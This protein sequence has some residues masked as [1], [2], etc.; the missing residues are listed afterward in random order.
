MQANT[1]K[2]AVEQQFSPV[3]ENYRTSAVHA[4]GEDLTQLVAAARLT[5][6]EV[7][8][9]AGSGAG[10]TALAVAPHAARVVAVDLSEAML[11]QGARGAEERGLTNV[12]F[13]QGDVE[14]LP[15]AAAAFD[16][17]VSR[18]SAHHWPHPQ[19]ALGEFR[20]LLRPGGRFLLS[21][22]VSYD[23]FTT[24]THLQALEVL[25][26][27]SHVRDHTVE[28]WRQMLDEAGFTA[29]VVFTWELRLEFDPWVQRIAT[30]PEEVAMLRR[31]FDH[32]PAEVRA[33]LQI[34]PDYAFTIQGALIRAEVA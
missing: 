31:L 23:D 33:R 32:A 22:I 14:A 12:E 3:A 16:V 20:R 2:D 10:H 1:I 30:P 34:G 25:R 4:A 24:D 5:G 9:D 28:A 21:D 17:I 19:R 13:R 6:R 15:F 26:D 18:Y 11:A 7:V 29:E 8:L 27:R